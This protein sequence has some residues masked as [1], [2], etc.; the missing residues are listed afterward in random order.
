MKDFKKKQLLSIAEFIDI[1]VNFDNVFFTKKTLIKKGLSKEE[2]LEINKI[3]L[4]NYEIETRHS[5][6][7]PLGDQIATLIGFYGKDGAQEGL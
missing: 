4:K 3:N 5:R 2:L 7:Y 1:D 6:H